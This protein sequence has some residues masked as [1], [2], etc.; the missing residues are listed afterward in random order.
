LALSES[1]RHDVAILAAARRG[2]RGAVGR[3]ERPITIVSGEAL[4]PPSP[5]SATV[6]CSRVNRAT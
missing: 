4:S 5:L 1:G 2:A 3:V 6:T